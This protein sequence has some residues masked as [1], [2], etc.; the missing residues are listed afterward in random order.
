[1][2]CHN[3]ISNGR[4][5]YCGLSRYFRWLPLLI[6]ISTAEIRIDVPKLINNLLPIINVYRYATPQIVKCSIYKKI[7]SLLKTPSSTV[8][9][10]QIT[11]LSSTVIMYTI[12]VPNLLQIVKVIKMAL[13]NSVNIR[14][15]LLI[16]SVP[17]ETMIST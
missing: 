12:C 1:M 4:K 5:R 14:C 7:N 16:K 6:E 2:M 9:H 10:I 8:L 17:L 13:I 15:F 3:V 11:N